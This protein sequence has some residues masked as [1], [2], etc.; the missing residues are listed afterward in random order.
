MKQWLARH[1]RIQ[2]HFTPTGASWLNL[3]ERWFALITGQAIRRG[4]FDSIRRLEA[5]IT[6]W[7]AAWNQN[8]KPFRWTKSAHQ[9]KRSIRNAALIYGRNTNVMNRK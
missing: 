5:A 1:P 6:N 3:V 8:A 9:I 2:L 4:S 7:L